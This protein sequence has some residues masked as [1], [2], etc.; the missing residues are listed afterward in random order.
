MEDQQ[1]SWLGSEEASPACLALLPRSKYLER[2]ARGI[3]TFLKVKKTKQS[4]EKQGQRGKKERAH[5]SLRTELCGTVI[6]DSAGHVI[7]LWPRSI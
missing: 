4:K 1:W 3:P 6:G 2:G 5:K 7:G